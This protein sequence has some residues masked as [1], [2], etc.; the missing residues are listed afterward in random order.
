MG[1]VAIVGNQRDEILAMLGLQLDLFYKILSVLADVKQTVDNEF[2]LLAAGTGQ[3]IILIRQHTEFK[4]IGTFIER[5][6][7]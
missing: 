1:E 5:G 2:Q 3:L 6:N 7:G 4:C